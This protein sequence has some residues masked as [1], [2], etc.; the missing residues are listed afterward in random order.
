MVRDRKSL[1]SISEMLRA[2][3]FDLDG[4]LLNS[5]P[6]LSK[7]AGKLMKE[8][9]GIPQ[10]IG[11]RMYKETSGMP[12]FRQLRRIHFDVFQTEL[13][14]DRARELNEKYQA[15]VDRNLRKF[16]FFPDVLKN[17]PLLSEDFF[18]FVS[19][20]TPQRRL[21][22]ILGLNKVRKYFKA[23]LGLESGFEKEKHF[24]FIEDVFDLKREELI[25]VGDTPY[26]YEVGSKNGILTILRSGTFSREELLKLTLFV[27]KDFNELREVV[28]KF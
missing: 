7:L 14:E 15:M 6:I 21:D 17:L 28:K 24:K 16:E 20:S 25:F 27:I 8:E 12:F 22:K 19:T 2:I 11:E 26:D 4:T 18:L 3:V 9:L 5:I 13:E 23:A 1:V 10:E